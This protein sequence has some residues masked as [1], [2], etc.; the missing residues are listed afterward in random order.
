MTVRSKHNNLLNYF[1]YDKKDLSK[2]Y[3][4]KCEIFFKEIEINNKE[5]RIKNE[6]TIKLEETK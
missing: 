5:Y 3:K 2:E 4:R 1:L 6:K